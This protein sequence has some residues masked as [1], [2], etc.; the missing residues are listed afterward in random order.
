MRCEDLTKQ[1]EELSQDL[2]LEKKKKM[3]LRESNDVKSPEA[4]KA[5]FILKTRHLSSASEP[6]IEEVS[7]L[8][9]AN[10][11][12]FFHADVTNS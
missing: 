8:V 5:E 11:L 1:I 10:A 4:T 6:E 12:R 7:A 3:R 2:E 9:N